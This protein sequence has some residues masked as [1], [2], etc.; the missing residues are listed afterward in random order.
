MSHGQSCDTEEAAFCA[1][2]HGS[3][4]V[5]TEWNGFVR[6]QVRLRDGEFA[7]P[8]LACID[9]QPYTTT[10]AGAAFLFLADYVRYR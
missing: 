2:R 7:G 4:A 6:N 10:Q 8:K 9:L 3:S 1:G 5:M